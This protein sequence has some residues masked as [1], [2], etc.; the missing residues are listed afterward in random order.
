MAAL[1]D[2][3]NH[4]PVVFPLLKMIYCQVDEFGSAQSATEQ[5]RQHCTIALPANAFPVRRSKRALACSA[6]SQF[7]SRTPT[8]LAPLTRR[9]PAA[10]SGLR[11][12]VS[13]APYARRRTAARRKF[14]VDGAKW[15][16]SS[17]NLYRR[18]TVLLKASLGSEQ[19]QVTKSSIANRYDRRD[20]DER[21]VFRTAVF[22]KSRS[23]KRSTR[24]GEE[25]LRF[26]VLIFM[27]QRSPCPLTDNVQIRS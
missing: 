27:G 9:M 23:G 15:R 8:F 20:S 3:V 19:Y 12:P 24:F 16:P 1:P 14:I 25:C 10:N 22:A 5:D 26:D 13:A 17:S 18:T 6:V 21:R 4:S 2:Y 7:P 11:S